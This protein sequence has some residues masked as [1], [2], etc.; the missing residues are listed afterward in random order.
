MQRIRLGKTSGVLQ[1]PPTGN[2]CGAS[3][4]RN[5]PVQNPIGFATKNG[6]A[7]MWQ[8][9]KTL[10][11]NYEKNEMHENVCQEPFVYFAS[12]VVDFVP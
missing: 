5:E 9:Y 11:K 8:K 6:F 1:Q 4:R 3:E 10:G 2:V 7:R 12:F